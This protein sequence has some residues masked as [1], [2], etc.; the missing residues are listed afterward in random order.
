MNITH[1]THKSSQDGVPEEISLWHKSILTLISFQDKKVL[2]IGCGAG[3]FLSY[4]QKKHNSQILGIDP[5]PANIKAAEKSGI[6]TFSGYASYCED[7]DFRN[8]D[9]V[10]SFEV[11][12]HT[13]DYKDIFVPAGKFL[14]PGGHL[15][16]TT[17]NAFHTLRLL[18]ML[19]GE[20]RDP[21]LDPTKN[22][23][24]EHI[25]LYSPAMITRAFEKSGFTAVRLYGALH[26][27]GKDIILKNKFLIQFFS[28][29]LIGVGEKK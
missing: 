22:D 12:E 29:H 1:Y 19:C 10:T 16:V 11:L 9:I 13:Y 5:N 23:E 26:F 2:D 15:V 25:R 14:K 21:L 17:P 28:Q 3:G 27:K 20:H 4:I 6:K 8:C 18:S 24:P 7:K